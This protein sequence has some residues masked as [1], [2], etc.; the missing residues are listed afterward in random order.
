MVCILLGNWK[1]IHDTMKSLHWSKLS[2]KKTTAIE[3]Q[4]RTAL[5]MS[6]FTSEIPENNS[7]KLSVTCSPVVS[8]N[9]WLAI[10]CSRDSSTHFANSRNKPRDCPA[11]RYLRWIRCSLLLSMDQWLWGNHWFHFWSLCNSI[12]IPFKLPP[13]ETETEMEGM[14]RDGT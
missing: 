5:F 12:D 11:Q 7:I 8:Q 13:E 2:V 1:K 10:R 6:S 14:A 9:F 3:N 4:L